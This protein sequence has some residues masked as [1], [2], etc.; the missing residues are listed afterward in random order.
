MELSCDYK[1]MNCYLTPIVLCR[2]LTKLDCKFEVM[3]HI[4]LKNEHPSLHNLMAQIP[5][6]PLNHV[7]NKHPPKCDLS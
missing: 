2:G 7:L 5:V 4:C 3:V 1:F 6:I